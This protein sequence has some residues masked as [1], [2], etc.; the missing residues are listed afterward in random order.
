MNL[1]K[2]TKRHYDL[3]EDLGHNYIPYNHTLMRLGAGRPTSELSTVRTRAERFMGLVVF[4]GIHRKLLV[5]SVLS[6]RTM[7][8]CY[9]TVIIKQ[10]AHRL[11]SLLDVL[12]KW[13]LN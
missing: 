13:C 6:S 7:P 12:H 5:D 10:K 4:P 9:N 3:L 2:R 11:G 1:C 8:V